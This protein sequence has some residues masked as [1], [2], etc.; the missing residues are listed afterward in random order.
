VY[1]VSGVRSRPI[2]VA[3]WK[4]HNRSG[5]DL[6]NKY[7]AYRQADQQIREL[8]LIVEDH[9]LKIEDQMSCL[10][11]IWETLE[12][13]L[14]VHYHTVFLVLKAKL[15]QCVDL[16][17]RIAGHSDGEASLIELLQNKGKLSKSKF[18]WSGKECL[19]KAIEELGEWHRMFDP[20][21]FLVKRISNTLIDYQL[22]TFQA[23]VSSPVSVLKSM[24]DNEHNGLHSAGLNVFISDA[25]VTRS[26][27][28]P[29]SP[30]HVA[31][32]AA[33]GSSVIIDTMVCRPD[34][35][36]STVIKDV[37]TLARELTKTDPL[38]FNLL[39]C[40]GVIKNDRPLPAQE[41]CDE[42]AP[43]LT[44]DFVFAVPQFLSRPRSLRDLL[45][46]KDKHPFLDEKVELSKQLANSVA[47]VHTA[48]F[49][50]KNI[51]PETILVF[52]QDSP[53]TGAAFLVGF[54]VFRMADG[55]SYGYRDTSWEKDIYQYPFQRG[56]CQEYYVMQHD[57]YTLGVCLLE[58]GFWESFVVTNKEGGDPRPGH[59]IDLSGA[60]AIKEEVKRA[61]RIKELLI[62]A[63]QEKLPIAVG[64]KYSNVVVSCLTCL[65]R[66][67]QGLGDESE[68]RDPAGVV[69]GVN[70]IEHVL[71]E[72]QRIT[73]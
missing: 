10:R 44:F 2:C 11:Q 30:V 4:R 27:K 14:Q 6:V 37:R 32:E 42:E 64:S 20:S 61:L 57:I 13:H 49:V 70:Y 51:R 16:I 68:F 18:A 3:D 55:R 58:I 67:N 47:F 54:E 8:T 45:L 17:A 21:W 7:K 15:Q 59:G 69:I 72:L 48:N 52:E 65:D 12:G 63:A 60:L 29:C 5:K 25:F 35:D 1:Q 50:H 71:L 40:R 46:H 73:V 19:E 36:T 31:Q 41:T 34:M 53:A 66:D 26:R 38:S 33:T 43:A 23:P 56:L 9:W 24:R 22:S 28:L 39:G 62:T